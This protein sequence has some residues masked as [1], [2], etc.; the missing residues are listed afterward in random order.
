[1]K[2]TMNRKLLKFWNYRQLAEK[3]HFVPM[4]TAYTLI[5]PDHLITVFDCSQKMKIC[6]TGKISDIYAGFN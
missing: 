4:S 5:I 6:H 3:V 1:M 2:K